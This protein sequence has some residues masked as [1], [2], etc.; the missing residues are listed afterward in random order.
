MKETFDMIKKFSKDGSTSNV[1][2]NSITT[3]ST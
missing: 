3:L 2:E 1:V